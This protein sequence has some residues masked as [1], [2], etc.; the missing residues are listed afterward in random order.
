MVRHIDLKKKNPSEICVSVVS[1]P[2][3]FYVH[4]DKTRISLDISTSH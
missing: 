1:C 3:D 2:R 4:V